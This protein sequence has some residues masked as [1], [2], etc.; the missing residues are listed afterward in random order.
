VVISKENDEW[1]KKGKR[2]ELEI[3]KKSIEEKGAII[4]AFILHMPIYVHIHLFI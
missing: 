2:K 1:D 4:L 3:P